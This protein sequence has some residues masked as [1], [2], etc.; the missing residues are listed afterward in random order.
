MWKKVLWAALA[1]VVLAVAAVA[2]YVATYRPAQRPAPDLTVERTPK[3]LA[4]GRYLVENVLACGD[5]HS[6]RDWSRY[7]GPVKGAFG[8]GGDCLGPEYGAPGQIC[9]PN[10]TPDPATGIG[11]WTDGEI[12]RAIREGVGRDGR[13][14]FPMMPYA[15]YRALSDEDAYAVVAYLRTVAPVTNRVSPTEIDFPVSF[16]VKAAPQPLA[17]PVAAPDRSDR[18][19][20]GRYLATVAGCAGCHTPV[21]ER[22]QPIPGMELAGGQVF[23]GPWGTVASANL[24][25]DPTGLG[26]K[27]EQSFLGMFRAFSDPAAAVPVPASANTIMPWLTHAGMTDDDLAAIWAYLRTVPPVARSV[28]RRPSA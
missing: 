19:A 4:R 10:I 6:Q 28:T 24:T 3:R 2:V 8:A 18:L 5:C 27:S 21:D 25:P 14:L 12:L 22:N 17:G 15:E 1:V 9:A 13:A 7:G 16:F 11:A 23:K 20:Y 26:G